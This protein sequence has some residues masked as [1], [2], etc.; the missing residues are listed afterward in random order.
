MSK[1]RNLHRRHQ[2]ILL[3]VWHGPLWTSMRKPYVEYPAI[4]V[5]PQYWITDGFLTKWIT[6]I[7]K[8]KVKN[9]IN[10][11]KFFRCFSG[12]TK[13]RDAPCENNA[14]CSDVIG[15]YRCLCPMGYSDFNCSTGRYSNNWY[16]RRGNITYNLLPLLKKNLGN[17]DSRVWRKQIQRFKK[18]IYKLWYI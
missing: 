5:L 4:T 7:G 12:Y 2:L 15:G 13:C 9:E 14:T 8:P 6:Q 16:I 3:Y 11:D 17:T 18:R 10:T 1:F